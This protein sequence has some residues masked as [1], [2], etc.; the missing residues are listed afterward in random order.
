MAGRIN[1]AELGLQLV[2]EECR[3]SLFYFVRTFWD[4][5]INEPPVFNWHIPY[6]CE[7]LEVLGRSVKARE[8]K[9]YDL[10]INIPPGTTK[11]TIV[12]IMFPVWLWVIDPSIQIITNSYSNGLSIEHAIKSKDIINSDKFRM[13]FPD[14]YIR[15]DKSGKQHYANRQGG[16]RYATSTG[17][18]IT[19]FHAHIIINDDPVNPKQAGSEQLRKSANEH[20]KTLSSRKV[21]KANTPVVTVMQRLHVDDVSGHQLKTKGETIRH[22]CLPA[23]V[24]GN[25]KPEELRERYVDG[26]LDPVR[27]NRTVLAEAKVDL[28]SVQY[29]GQ[30]EQSPV[31]DGGNIVKEDWFRRISMS[32]FTAMRFREPMHFYLDT[33]YSKKKKNS[34]NDPSG[35]LAACR[36]KNNIYLYDAQKVYKD[37]PDLLRFLPEYAAAHGYD[38]ESILHIEPR[39]NGESVVQMIEEYSTM[40]VKRTPSPTDEKAVRFKAVSPRI[41]CGRVYIVEGGWNEEFLAEVCSFPNAP[42]DEYVDILGYA[43]NDLMKDDDDIDWSDFSKSMFGL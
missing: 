5:I 34:D 39:A 1:Y 11:S 12:T 25:V 36:I 27:L 30:Y 13:L 15:R 43:I 14:I 6:L 24:T 4:V 19:G 23:E 41:E 7:E 28:G 40:N 18:T 37:M 38:D 21:D 17:A 35:I 20:I 26:L 3:R 22:I 16:F 10:I 9:P 8:P 31:A 2:A 33:A 42:H 29:A 32:E